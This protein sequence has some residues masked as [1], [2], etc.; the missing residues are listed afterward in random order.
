MTEARMQTPGTSLASCPAA[1][2]WLSTAALAGA[3]AACGGGSGGAAPA[4]PATGDN[5]PGGDTPLVVVT[6]NDPATAGP[7]ADALT[8]PGETPQ[9]PSTPP[10]RPAS[11]RCAP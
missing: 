3:L 8:P 6:P 1:W 11:V 7:P 9:D 4:G 10:R 5:K 2:R